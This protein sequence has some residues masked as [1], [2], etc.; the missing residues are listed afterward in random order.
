MRKVHYALG[1]VLILALAGLMGGCAWLFPSLQAVLVATPTS[2]AAPLSVQFDASG[3]TGQIVSWSLNFGDGSAPYTGTAANIGTP[4]VHL[5]TTPGTYTATLTVQGP[6][7]QT[8]TD[9]VTITVQPG[10]TAS[11]SVV[12]GAGHA[13]L[14]VLFTLSASAA[15]GRTLAS[16]VLDPGDPAGLTPPV[17]FPVSGPTFFN[18]FPYTYDD[19]GTYTAILTVTDSA[20]QTASAS[21]TITVTSPPPEIT[22]FTADTSG[23]P[24]V[25]FDFTAQAGAGRNIVEWTI[26]Y[27]DN[28]SFTQSGLN[29][30]TLTVTGH[31]HTYADPGDY[32]VTL[33]VKDDAGETDT[34]TLDITLGP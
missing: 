12:P 30:P 21:V 14:D 7:G 23:A 5:Y 13:P 31:A 1:A 34:E 29:T 2:G 10:T 25:T 15:P 6:G 4:V 33:T 32:T 18:I 3:S 8:D 22:S 28:T 16:A 11:L 9:Q 17:S 24:T 19:P 26:D 27:G 20:G